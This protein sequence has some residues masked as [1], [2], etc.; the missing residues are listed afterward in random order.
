MF[1]ECVLPAPSG[2]T[3]DAS[4]QARNGLCKLP[5]F[6]PVALKIVNLLANE[7]VD[8]QGV[9]G[10]LRS[11]P[12]LSAEVLALAN[13]AFYG[14]SHHIDNLAR[15][16]LVL[17]FR[18]T[19]SLALTVALRSFMRHL[20]ITKVMEACWQH[21]LAA[22]LLAEELAPLY[23]ISTDQAYTAALM[24]DVGRLGLLMAYGDVYAPLL[25]APHSTP[26]TCLDS[27]RNLFQMD[28]C[29][30][31]L[32]VTQRWGFPPEY[33]RAAGCHHEE[34]PARK[35]DLASLAGVACRLADA[36]GF[37]AVAFDQ[38][39]SASEIVAQLPS[40]PWN[41]YVFNEEDLRSRIAKQ[42]RA[43]EGS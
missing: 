37:S 29:Q 42:V 12:G 17:G 21:S 16:V 28:H 5:V 2:A 15:A 30:A 9:A 24:H 18:R 10:L 13:S 22:A 1:V 34:L 25:E 32:W 31:G 43:V 27:E 36:L 14:Q 33:S 38:A 26:G 40:D 6:R 11:D 7:E 4:I 23:E 3:A 41:R 8:V 20:T 39:P 35:Q 19:K